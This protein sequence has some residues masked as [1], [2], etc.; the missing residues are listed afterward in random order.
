MS[1]ACRLPADAGHCIIV[2]MQ[3]LPILQGFLFG[4]VLQL[5]VGPVCLAVFRKAVEGRL[6]PA[7]WMVAGVA[8]ADGAYIALALL[9]VASFLRIDTLRVIV[10]LAGAL[11]LA[12]FGVRLIR[13]E[14]A[15][16]AAETSGG[17]LASLRYGF[18]LT[19]ANPLTVVFWGG[20]FAGVAASTELAG[21]GD[22][23]PFAAGCLLSTLAFLSAVAVFGRSLS[24]LLSN[25]KALRWLNRVV[26][27]V[28]VGFAAK[29]A[30]D[31][32]T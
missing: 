29:L 15:P 24:P 13:A 17:S 8:A 25:G 14:A 20:V 6:G 7:L 28:L 5:S 18:L 21:S 22:V 10:G 9:G 32:L 16:A 3:T 11:V 31:V 12:V 1:M 30:V 23:Y 2:A 4:M 19:V 27:I 26:G